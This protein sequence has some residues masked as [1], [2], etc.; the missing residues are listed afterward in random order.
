MM[1]IL[2]REISR[3]CCGVRTGA[4]ESEQRE[5]EQEHS[6]SAAESIL[7]VDYDTILHVVKLHDAMHLQK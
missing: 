6:A 2:R 3:V 4:A 1:F 5:S 7:I